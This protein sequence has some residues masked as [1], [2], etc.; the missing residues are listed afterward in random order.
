VFSDNFN[1]EFDCVGCTIESQKGFHPNGD[2][3]N[4][5]APCFGVSGMQTVVKVATNVLNAK[6]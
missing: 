4:M 5:L 1:D 2:M 6:C 3:K